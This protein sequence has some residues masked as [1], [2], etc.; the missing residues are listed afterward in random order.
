MYQESAT[1]YKPDSYAVV[2]CCVVEMDG[3]SVTSV[4]EKGGPVPIF[5]I[6][7]EIPE[8]IGEILTGSFMRHLRNFCVS[9]KI[10][11]YK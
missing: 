11:Q 4:E 7:S 10:I 2:V 6:E 9:I 8:L 1:T 3:L 5:G